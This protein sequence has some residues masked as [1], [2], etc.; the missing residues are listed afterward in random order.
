M[1]ARLGR[2]K[3]YPLRKDWEEVK[4]QTMFRVVYAK[5]TQ[6]AELKKL[7][8]STGNAKLVEHTSNDRY[9]YV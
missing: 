5:F 1:Q 8:L 2:N 4:D 6:N 3:S 9:W 7:L